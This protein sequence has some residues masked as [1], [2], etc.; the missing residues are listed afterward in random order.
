[1]HKLSKLEVFVDKLFFFYVIVC[2]LPIH[3]LSEVQQLTVVEFLADI[4]N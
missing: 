4:F 3:S 1:M 2:F